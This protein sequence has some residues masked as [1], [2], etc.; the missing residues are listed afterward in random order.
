MSVE[1]KSKPE[2]D[3]RVNSLERLAKSIFRTP[4]GFLVIVLCIV[5]YY[6]F[7]VIQDLQQQL[8]VSN[9]EH[10]QDLK[11]IKSGLEKISDTTTVNHEDHK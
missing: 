6:E 11:N 8:K 10:I 3:S 9:T 5:A 2:I 4:Y 7:K 1:N